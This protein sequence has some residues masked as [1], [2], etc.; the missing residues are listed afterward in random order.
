M[1][2]PTYAPV[3]DYDEE[4]ALREIIEAIRADNGSCSG[5]S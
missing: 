3:I 2:K 4:I 1:S 5:E